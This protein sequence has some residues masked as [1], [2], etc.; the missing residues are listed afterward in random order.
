[1]VVS[2]PPAL[3]ER[4][5]PLCVAV[6]A[7]DKGELFRLAAGALK[8]SRFVELR[9][10]ALA[11]PGAA[12]GALAAFCAEHT[13][14]SVL[15]T[16]RRRGGGGGFAGTVEEQL[17]LL[18][19][20]AR[21][22]AVLVDVELETLEAA[23][24]KQLATLREQLATP[25]ERPGG[26]S[27]VVSSHDFEG[28]GDL[29]TT[30]ARL[31]KRGAPAGAA[32]F[33]VVST[34][35]EL[36]DNDRMLKWM[37]DASRE[38]PVVGL[39]MGEAGLPSRVLARRAG[40]LWTFASAEGGQRTAPGQV[41]AGELIDGYGV[42]GIGP[43][44][45]IYG[46]AGN[47]VG[48]SLSPAMHNAG[49]RAAGVDAVYLPLL[50]TSLEDLMA[51]VRALPVAGLSV[52]M[53]WKVAMV[54]HLDEVDRLAAAIGAV[55]T[56]VRRE[57]GSLWGTNTDAAAVVEP[58][59]EHLERQ[60]TKLRGARVLLLGAGGAARAAAFGLR[61]E[62]AEVAILNRTVAAAERLAEA[63]GATVA[64]AGRLGG[65]D[66][67]VNATPA[68]MA[69]QGGVELPVGAEAL[70]GAR[71]LFEMVYRP[72]DTPL[73]RLGGELGIPVLDGLAMFVHQ[74]ARQWT[75]WTGR[76]A[77]A[78]AMR[79]AAEQALGRT[80]KGAVDE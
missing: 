25:A 32:I 13:E 2:L 40:A 14:A 66:A 70:R 79:A 51:L 6:T 72:A 69:G 57:D 36:F 10:D 49:F 8:R 43:E 62:G 50:T 41:S 78:A 61:A 24:E 52:T 17:A 30:L 7:R 12:V 73:T 54:P 64:D 80:G 23:T 16:C 63:C 34:A 9:F 55:N 46:V 15:A 37:E 76:E 39:C 42:R 75:L 68:G 11:E 26:A 28:T 35:V 59:R 29:S 44:T 45:R 47:P 60:G 18:A 20:F 4:L 67:V 27:L 33:K 31:R 3:R 71:V 22:G 77:P 65:Y 48:H 58:L 19:D 38:V 74:G 21:A 53:P 56:V 1:M 5:D